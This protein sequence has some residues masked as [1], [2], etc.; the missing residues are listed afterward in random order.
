MDSEGENTGKVEELLEEGMLLY[1]MGK[2]EEAGKKW[3]RVLEIAPDNPMAEEYLKILKEDAEPA[4]ETEPEHESPPPQ[5]ESTVKQPEGPESADQMVEKG[6]AL[7]DEGDHEGAFDRFKRAIDAGKND[8]DTFGYLETA[9]AAM[10]NDYKKLITDLD[11]VPEIKMNYDRIKNMD[12]NN[13]EGFILSQIDGSISF[14]DIMA[15]TGTETVQAMG[16]F[17]KFVKSGIIEVK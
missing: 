16:V 17:A 7:L 9:R 14:R 6:R 12:L 2:F 10:L 3:K 13:Q 8:P 15:L 4:S 11:G 5:A 1:G